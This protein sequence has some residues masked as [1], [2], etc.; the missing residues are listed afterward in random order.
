MEQKKKT[1]KTNIT[2]EKKEIKKEINDD[3]ENN[4]KIIIIALILALMVALIA[5]VQISKNEDEKELGNKKQDIIE[6]E[7][8]VD[9]EDEEEEKKSGSVTKIENG[10]YNTVSTLK[11][12]S[13]VKNSN[14]ENNS[15]SSKKDDDPIYYSIT[16]EANGGS[17]VDQQILEDDEVTVEVTTTKDGWNFEGWYED[18]EFNIPFEFGKVLTE[19][20]TV[21]AKWT[22]NV[23]YMIDGQLSDKVNKVVLNGEI[24]L[25]SADDLGISADD[26]E[27]AWSITSKDEYGQT[28]YKIVQDGTKYTDSESTEDLVLVMT[29]LSK[30]NVTFYWDKETEEVITT[31]KVTEGKVLDLTEAD[32][33]VKEKLSDQEFGWYY[34]DSDGNQIDFAH[35]SVANKE[36][37]KLYVSDVYTVI[38]NEE[39]ETE[40][41]KE[42]KEIDEQKVTK[43]SKIGEVLEPEEKEDETFDGWYIMDEGETTDE[44]LTE[45]TIIDKDLNVIGKWNSISKEETKPEENI[46]VSEEPKQNSQEEENPVKE[47][48]SQEIPEDEKKSA[49][50]ALDETTNSPIIEETEQVEEIN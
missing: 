47:P 1:N 13:N 44:K 33:I 16:F 17:E 48:T 27:I 40:D 22:K 15:N 25:L 8:I 39:I 10:V 26:F 37:T 38:Y 30:F 50:E 23:K 2:K 36:I 41:G 31:Q 45:E 7:E 29:K 46:T 11:K 34:I 49:E 42:I 28:E 24:P 4:K 35:G 19:D 3:N 18:E 32:S 9:D 5:Y 21:Y 12:V 14:D 43:D 6:K 20:I